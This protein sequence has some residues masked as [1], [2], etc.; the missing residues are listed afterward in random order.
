MS[1]HPLASPFTVIAVSYH[2][3]PGEISHYLSGLKH[4]KKPYSID[5]RCISSENIF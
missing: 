1:V 5:Q 4:N 2:L 3:P